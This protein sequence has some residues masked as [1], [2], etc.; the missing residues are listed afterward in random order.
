MGIKNEARGKLTE[1]LNVLTDRF[2]QTTDASEQATITEAI[3]QLNNIR[4]RLN[5]DDLQDAANAIQSATIS[6][7]RVVNS[8]RLGPFDD[9]VKAI[10]GVITRTNQLLRNGELSEPSPR[11][12]EPP[13]APSPASP[14]STS[15]TTTAPSS[16]P[17]Q[18]TPASPVP[19][20]SPSTHRMPANGLTIDPSKDF[21][22]L[23]VEYERFFGTLVIKADQQ[24]KVD[25]HVNQLLKNQS[26]YQ[27]VGSTVN[28]VPW[29]V[30]GI[31]HAMECG[32]NFACHLH[33]GDPLTR[34]TSHVPAGHPRN[35]TPPFP[36]EA[37]AVDALK[38][39]GLANVTDWSIPHILYLF[40]K[41]NG[42]G[43]RNMRLSTPYLW[44]FSNHYE[45]G[46]YVA[47]GHFDPQVISQQCGAAVMVRALTERG[48][49]IN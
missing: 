4:A 3:N 12:I 9:F 26:R 34:Q 25:W 19:P 29:A 17:S 24:S 1:A 7:E 45:K 16:R 21:A 30:V 22:V 18:P 5:Q 35:G 41:F 44:S 32:F 46:K 42:F 23:R 27:S 47:D 2:S 43:Y 14:G 11:A 13:G 36:W 40:E 10:E 6:L 49:K 20:S 37:S 39:D 48:V 28:N 8:A 15:S 33:N 38:L 31:I